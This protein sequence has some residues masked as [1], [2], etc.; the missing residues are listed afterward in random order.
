MKVRTL[1]V[2]PSC[3]QA[4]AKPAFAAPHVPAAPEVL[5][6]VAAGDL[7][8]AAGLLGAAGVGLGVAAGLSGAAG[9]GLGVAAGLLGAAG[10][11]IVVLLLYMLTGKGMYSKTLYSYTGLI[12]RLAFFES[13]A[14]V[15]CQ[16]G[17]LN[18][19]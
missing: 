16:G 8:V 3:G 7:G 9:V 2:C 11:G 15:D 13:S 18:T 6:G 12:R 5:G 10:V 1:Y 17:I 19:C 14:M 4:D